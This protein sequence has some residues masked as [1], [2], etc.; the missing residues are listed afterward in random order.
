MSGPQPHVSSPLSS[1]ASTGL[2]FGSGPADRDDIVINE[3]NRKQVLAGLKPGEFITYNSDGRPAHARN[4]DQVVGVVI[5][6]DEDGETLIRG[7]QHVELKASDHGLSVNDIGVQHLEPRRFPM[8]ESQ[9]MRNLKEEDIF[10]HI[11]RAE[12]H[13]AKQ[14]AERFMKNTKGAY[15]LNT[16][17]K[18]VIPLDEFKILRIEGKPKRF[19]VY[20]VTGQGMTLRGTYKIVVKHIEGWTGT[21]LTLEVNNF[22]RD[23]LRDKDPN[24]EKFGFYVNATVEEQVDADLLRVVDQPGQTAWIFIE[25]EV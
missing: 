6:K 20:I 10:A 22:S 18:E 4:G 19:K 11:E 7:Y 15:L 1:K 21:T 9:S 2:V 17:S 14:E 13:A 8:L 24:R 5:G 25:E 12:D 16:T 23:R 3:E